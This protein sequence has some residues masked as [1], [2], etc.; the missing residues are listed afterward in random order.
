MYDME[1]KNRSFKRMSEYLQDKGVKNN[2]FMFK[3]LNHELVGKSVDELL[4]IDDEEKLAKIK[5]SII[6]ECKNNIWYFFREVIK[7]PI[8]GLQHNYEDCVYFPLSPLSMAM[9]WC[10]EHGISFY[11]YTD[12]DD[13]Y[14]Y[15]TMVWLYIYDNFVKDSLYNKIITFSN[16]NNIKKLYDTIM[17]FS[18]INNKILHSLKLM[19]NEEFFIDNIIANLNKLNSTSFINNNDNNFFVNQ[20]KVTWFLFNNNDNMDAMRQLPMFE[21]NNIP[22]YIESKV[23]D[24]STEIGN[25]Q[26]IILKSFMTSFNVEMYDKTNMDIKS[27]SINTTYDEMGYKKFI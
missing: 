11:A 21:K 23:F 14:R 26:N 5:L 10:Y 25:I 7:I 2:I 20:E 18:N 6:E 3:T 19:I 13:F 9:I 27:L 12:S 8:P 22:F 24:D 15:E 16:S 17:K 1:T 4:Q